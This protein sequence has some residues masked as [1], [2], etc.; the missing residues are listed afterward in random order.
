MIELYSQQRQDQCHAKI[1]ILMRM[2]RLIISIIST[3]ASS[4]MI[5][6]I[7]IIHNQW[8]PP[9]LR[10]V[11]DVTAH[12]IQP[13]RWVVYVSTSRRPL[14]FPPV[15]CVI[16]VVVCIV[17]SMLPK[18]WRRCSIRRSHHDRNITRMTRVVIHIT[19]LLPRTTSLLLLLLPILREDGIP[20]SSMK[21]NTY[22]ITGTRL[23]TSVRVILIVRIIPVP[24]PVSL[25]AGVTAKEEETT[26]VRPPPRC[27]MPP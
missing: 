7:V 27:V 22:V 1:L 6:V 23:D 4:V 20:G 25:P 5:L 9:P 3:W 10:V 15:R 13:P 18:P 24:V 8:C 12:M 21:C 2:R 17:R 14:I 19:I 16:I 26:S 11:L